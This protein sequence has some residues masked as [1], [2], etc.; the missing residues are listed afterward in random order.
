MYYEG[1][2]INRI[3]IGR[4]MG[5]GAISSVVING[6]IIGSGTTTLNNITTL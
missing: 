5:F 3:I 2:N 1:D 4:D 6:N